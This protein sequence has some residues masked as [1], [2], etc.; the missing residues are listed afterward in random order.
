[1][2]RLA[3]AVFFTAVSCAFAQSPEALFSSQLG[4]MLE[5]ASKSGRELGQVVIERQ[6]ES[7]PQRLLENVMIAMY[8]APGTG[9]RI[10]QW[11]RDNKVAVRFK[12]DVPGGSSRSGHAIIIDSSYGKEPVSYRYLGTRIAKEAAELM[13]SDFPESA[14]KRYIVASRM[15]ETYFEL[16]GAHSSLPDFDGVKDPALAETLRVWIENAPEGGVETLKRGGHETLASMQTR[17]ESRREGLQRT[18]QAIIDALPQ[19]AG[20]EWERLK[21]ALQ[22]NSYELANVQMALDSVEA[23]AK[24]FKRFSGE[25]RDWIMNHAPL[26]G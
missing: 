13:L 16:G 22:D 15:A 17:L 11:L 21:Q 3:V 6:G 19:A 26:G 2:I 4:T 8:D 12:D 24:A 9:E 18:R 5:G 10:V 20:P 1:M 23:G 7:R 14:E 25:E